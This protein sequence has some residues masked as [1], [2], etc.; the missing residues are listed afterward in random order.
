MV[1]MWSWQEHNRVAVNVAGNCNG[2][3]P[4]SRQVA[5]LLSPDWSPGSSAGWRMMWRLRTD[6]GRDVICLF[7]VDGSALC[8][9]RSCSFGVRIR[10]IFCIFVLFCC[11]IFCLFLLYFLSFLLS[12]LLSFCLFAFLPYYLFTV[13]TVT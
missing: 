10:T 2:C 7:V 4:H 8:S 13:H 3:L 1:V 5:S 9:G 11:C 12:F 6:N